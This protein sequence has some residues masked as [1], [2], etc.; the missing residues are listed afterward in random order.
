MD[1]L[2]AVLLFAVGLVLIVKGGDLFV[3]AATWIAEVSGV[4]KFIVGA[5]VV[6]FA[7]TLPELIVS[8]MAALEG[9]VDMAVGNAV[10]S[11]TANTG[12][13]LGIA[14][15]FMPCVIQRKIYAFKSVLLIAAAGLTLLFSLG[16]SLIL[17]G[18]IVLLLTLA[19]FMWENVTSAKKQLADA[20]SEGRPA[21]DR[22]TVISNIVRFVLGTAGI[23]IGSRLMV[24]NGS[25][26]ALA[27]G[28]SEGV[29]AVTLVAVGTSLP[30]LVTT[31][32][33]I[34]K[35]QSALSFGNVIGANIIDLCMIM[36]VC[37]LASGQ[38]L[39]ISQQ[40]LLLDMP[41]CLAVA[42]VALI[43]MLITG[44]FSRWQGIVL[45]AGYAAY[46]VATVV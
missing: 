14:L 23:V 24:D 35:K 31:I 20:P 22:K 36:P 7:T 37:A 42:A 28:V 10:G 5:T 6:S 43:P 25:K 44:K 9:K 46:V 34:V 39:P 8:L 13:I 26:L 40:G 1:I 21:H 32:T 38:A 4:P 16:G 45:V 3:D 15:I 2:I 17:P 11:V 41:V 29:I 33:A 19:A 30:E 12:L 27:A 18:C